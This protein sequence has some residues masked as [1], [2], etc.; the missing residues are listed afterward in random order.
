MAYVKRDTTRLS[1]HADVGSISFDNRHRSQSESHIMESLSL[2]WHRRANDEPH[3]HPNSRTI[4]SLSDPLPSQQNKSESRSTSPSQPRHKTIYSH[5]S[6]NFLL[7]ALWIATAATSFSSSVLLRAM[8]AH[9][10]S[11]GP[12][13]FGRESPHSLHDK[14]DQV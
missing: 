7:R 9:H 6:P 14:Q 3:S 8:L 4:V 13:R 1:V 2:S 10:L 12:G 5:K 11:Q